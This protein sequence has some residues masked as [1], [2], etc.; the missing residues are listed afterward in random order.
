MTLSAFL[1]PTS[2]TSGSTE[3]AELVQNPIWRVIRTSLF[4]APEANQSSQRS[5][6]HPPDQDHIRPDFDMELSLE[7][8]AVVGP[9]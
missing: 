3:V 7:M 1:G 9:K 5:F 2:P 8:R 6:L 4:A